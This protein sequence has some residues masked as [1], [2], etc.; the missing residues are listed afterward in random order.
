[1]VQVVSPAPSP[2]PVVSM[3]RP[4]G[5]STAGRLLFA[6]PE[7]EPEA[8][9]SGILAPPNCAPHPSK[10]SARRASPS[11]CARI[12]RAKTPAL[13]AD[14]DLRSRSRAPAGDASLGASAGEVFP[15]ALRSGAQEMGCHLCI[16]GSRARR[17]RRGE[18]L[19]DPYPAELRTSPV[20][21]VG[22]QSLAERMRSHRTGQRPRLSAPT[23]IAD[24][25]RALRPGTHPL[26]LRPEAQPLALRPGT[27]NGG[28]PAVWVI[29][30]RTEGISERGAPLRARAASQSAVTRHALRRGRPGGSCRPPSRRS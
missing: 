27:Q 30:P 23:L 17:S 4:V 7:A 22:T 3:T 25:D 26:A 11:G 16:P 6:F 9:L 15:C 13:R 20:E 12:A 28:E 21:A 19:R 5:S 2:P 29:P 1:M 18:A 14:L 24:Q 10:P 8:R